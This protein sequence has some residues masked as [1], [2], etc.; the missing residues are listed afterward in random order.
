MS[1]Q[2]PV[3]PDIIYSNTEKPFSVEDGDTEEKLMKYNKRA[4]MLYAW[5]CWVTAHARQRLKLAVNI[6]DEDF[7]YCDTDSCKILITERYPEIQSVKERFFGKWWSCYRPKG[8]R[9]LSGRIRV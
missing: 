1:A 3:K 9:T 2:N 5:G 8:R 4:F 6:A 7:V